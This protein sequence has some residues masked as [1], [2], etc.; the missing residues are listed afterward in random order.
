MKAFLLKL[1]ETS[2]SEFLFPSPKKEGSR[3]TDIKKAFNAAVKEAGIK[4]FHFHDLRH[5]FGTRAADG[6]VEMTAIAE[7]MGHADIRTTRRYSHATD[8]GRRR[9]VEAV[10]KHSM[11]LVTIRSQKAAG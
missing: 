11:N 5:T 2:Q 8:Q 9:V 1:K 6:G 7:V 10:E 4:D 3:I